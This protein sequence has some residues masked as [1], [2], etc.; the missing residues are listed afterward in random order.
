MTERKAAYNSPTQMRSIDTVHQSRF[1]GGSTA[2]VLKTT[3]YFALAADT[4]MVSLGSQMED[5]GKTNK[6]KLAGSFAYV[7]VG[8]YRDSKGILDVDQIVAEAA[9]RSIDLYQ[10]HLIVI[11]EISKKV[12]AAFADIKVTNPDCYNNFIL[13]KH[14]S[15]SIAFIGLVENNLTII[16]SHFL[17]SD[18]SCT[19]NLINTSEPLGLLL[20]GAHS[21]IDKY[22]D[23]NPNPLRNGLE[24]GMEFLI[25][26]EAKKQPDC[27]A[28]P[29]DLLILDKS[30]FRWLRHTK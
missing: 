15:I 13:N 16:A 24:Y 22:L 9:K 26:L 7:N 18:N 19:H 20:F 1:V 17:G 2:I 10:V 14:N 30:G 27:V 12:P 29:I 8:L 11:D 4:K 5:A 23:N 6:I 3:E 21:E 28:L 25:G